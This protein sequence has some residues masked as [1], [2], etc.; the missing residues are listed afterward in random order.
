LVNYGKGHGAKSTGHG[1]RSVEQGAWSRGHGAGGMEQG[2]WSRGH[3]AKPG[4]FSPLEKGGW[5]E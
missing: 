3:G 1:A 4:F 5:R 2:K